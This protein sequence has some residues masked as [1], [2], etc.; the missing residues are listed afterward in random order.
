MLTLLDNFGTHVCNG[1]FLLVLELKNANFLNNQGF[2]SI[3]RSRLPTSILN[4]VSI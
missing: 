4:G 2:N 1:A 3:E